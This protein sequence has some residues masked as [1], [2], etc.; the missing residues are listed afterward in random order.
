MM[1]DK[2][3]EPANS[4]APDAK[5]SCCS[6]PAHSHQNDSNHS[7]PAEIAIDPVCGMEVA[8]AGAKHVA[9]HGGHDYY[10]CSGRCRERFV[11]DPQQYLTGSHKQAAADLPEGT[12][13]T[14]PMHP[15]IRQVG[16]GSCP[17]CGMALEPETVSLDDGPDPELIDMSRRFRWSASSCSGSCR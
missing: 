17:I 3:P 13:Y 15:E 4:V 7:P 14:C 8:I 11:A 12:I 2:H 5:A 16:P 9:A 6:N 10:F 1:S